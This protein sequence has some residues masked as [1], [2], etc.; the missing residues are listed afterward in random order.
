[1]LKTAILFTDN[2]ILQRDKPVAVWGTAAPGAAVRVTMQ[3]RTAKA[4]ADRCGNWTAICGPF[5]TSFCE[6]MTVASGSEMMEYTNA[7][8]GEVWLAGGQSNMEFHMRYD[9]DFP[10]EQSRCAND[11]IRFFDYPE[12]SYPSQI[13]EADFLKTCGFWRIAAPDQLE[14]FSAVGYYF[15]KDLWEKLRV[16][17]GILG[18]NWGGTPAAAWMSREAILS[19]GGQLLMDEYAKNEQALDLEA[20]ERWFRSDPA[21][22]RVDQLDNPINDVLMRGGSEEELIRGFAAIG[23]DMS[24]AKP[25]DFQPVIGPKHERRPCGLYESMLC[26]VAPYTLRGVIW[27]QGETDGD[28]H[29][30]LYQSLFPALIRNWRD[31]WREELPFLFVQIAPLG[32]WLDCMGNNYV[33]VRKAQQHTADTVPGTG[34]AVITD[35]GMENDIHP[36]K[37]QPVG[38]RL[39]LLALDR[40]Y[41]RPTLC[42]APTLCAAFWEGRKLNLS[43]ENSGDGLYLAELTPDGCV[44]DAS[45]LGGLQVFQNGR[46]LDPYTLTAKAEGGRVIVS[47]P[48]LCTGEETSVKLA[49]TG[50]YR[51]NLYN[52]AGIPA[53]PAE[54]KVRE[55]S[56]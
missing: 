31:L 9:Q 20:Y 5:R 47:G 19:G 10:A 34:M 39:A 52:S 8:V 26:R 30:E 55:E 12:V 32:Q 54:R 41:S 13:E 28:T 51:V 16:P 43:F 50:W 14:R 36:K 35:I 25:E 18:C 6:T 53:R 15:A 21:S 48:M 11:H 1:M 37:K 44:T 22:W 17:I 7:Q 38:H 2:M 56:K 40:V 27:Y 23:L 42:E 46:E 24:Q 49:M 4:T 33:S 45:R 29:P 3:G